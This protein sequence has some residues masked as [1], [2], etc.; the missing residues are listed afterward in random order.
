MTIALNVA[1][2]RHSWKGICKVSQKVVPLYNGFMISQKVVPLH[3]GFIIYHVITNITWGIS[4]DGISVSLDCCIT[5][6]WNPMNKNFVFN[7]YGIFLQTLNCTKR[8]YTTSSLRESRPWLWDSV[9]SQ[10]NLSDK[11]K[12]GLTI[13]SIFLLLARCHI[14]ISAYIC[15]VSVNC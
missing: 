5:W 4:F 9:S 10:S 15:F 13:P 8:C 14:I 2:T 6:I 11:Q 12:F 1:R 3:N 7:V